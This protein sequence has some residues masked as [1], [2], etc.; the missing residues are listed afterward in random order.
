LKAKT[1]SNPKFK[2]K[3]SKRRSQNQ[4]PPKNQAERSPREN[5]QPRECF[6]QPRDKLLRSGGRANFYGGCVVDALEGW[7]RWRR[8][9]LLYGFGGGDP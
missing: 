8:W 1:V 9:G 4:Q 3:T 7:V 5:F 2:A 6:Q